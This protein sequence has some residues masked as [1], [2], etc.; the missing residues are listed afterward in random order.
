MKRG[1]FRVLAALLVFTFVISAMT[2]TISALSYVKGTNNVSSSYK[3]GKFYKQLTQLPLTGNQRADVLAVALSQVQ[4]MESNS[5]SDLSGTTGGSNNYTE[6]CYN[7]GYDVGTNYAWCAAFVTWCLRQSGVN[8]VGTG[9]SNLARSHLGDS[10]Y[11]YCEISCGFWVSQLQKCGYWKG[12]KGRF[13]GTYAPKPGDL[14][15]FENGGDS[16]SDHIGMVVYYDSSA[17]KV[18][19]VEGN[20][21]GASGVVANGGRVA[22]KSY[23]YSST[24][25]YGYGA[26]PYNNSTSPIDYSGKNPSAGIYIAAESNKYLYS[27]SACTGTYAVL[28]KG[29]TFEVTGIAS[30]SGLNAVL[31]CKYNGNT[32]YIKNNSDRII[33][34]TKTVTDSGTGSGSES[35]SGSGSGGTTTTPTTLTTTTAYQQ[36]ACI[37]YINNAGADGSSNPYSSDN[38]ANR[39]NPVSMACPKQTSDGVLNVRGWCM[40]NG[41]QSEV[42]YSLNGGT[43]WTK[44]STATYSNGNSAHKNAAVSLGLTSD[45]AIVTNAVFNVSVDLSAYNGKSVD[46][47]F[48]RI[49]SGTMYVSH[50]LTVTGVVVGGSLVNPVINGT[51]ALSSTSS[52]CPLAYHGCIDSINGTKSATYGIS[53]NPYRAVSESASS[54]HYVTATGVTAAAGNVLTVSGW[55]LMRGGQNKYVYSIDGKNWYNCG[56]TLKTAEAAVKTAVENA[57]YLKSDGDSAIDTANGRYVLNLDLSGCAGTTVNVYVGVV[58]AFSGYTNRVTQFLVIKNVSVPKTVYSTAAVVNYIDATG[59]DGTTDTNYANDLVAM[60]GNIPTIPIAN[61]ISCSKKTLRITGWCMI[62]GG[63]Q[64]TIKWSLDGGSTWSGTCSGAYAD[65]SDSNT[66]C[67][68][69]WCNMTSPSVTGARF[70]V[71]ANLSDVTGNTV[72]VTFGRLGADGKMYKFLTITDVDMTKADHKFVTAE[73]VAPTCTAAGSTEKI[74]CSSCGYVKQ[75]STSVSATGHSWKDATCTAPKTCMV[76]SATTG[77]ANGHVWVDANCT[78]PKTCSVCKVT[79][80]KATGHSWQPATC[81]SPMTCSGCKA[82]TGSAAGHSWKD[83]TCTAPKTCTVCST[84]TGSAKGH[85]WKDATVTAPKT[86]SVCG[87]TEGKPIEKTGDVNVIVLAGQSNAY[88][89]TPTDYSGYNIRNLYGNKTYSNIFIHYNN[90]NL[91]ADSSS[92]DGFRWRTITSNAAFERYKVG[93]GAEASTRFGPEL[94]LANYLNETYPDEDFYII[95]FTAAGTFLNGQWFASDGNG[96]DPYGLKDDMGDYLYAQMRQYI[97]SSIGMIESATGKN[98]KITSFMWVQG[99]SDAG[100]PLSAG[101]YKNCEQL[102]V[103]SLRSDFAAY[104]AEGGISFIDMTISEKIHADSSSDGLA[105]AG[106]KI[107]LYSSEINAAKR[108]NAQYDFTGSVVIENSNAG[109]AK[110]ILIDYPTWCSKYEIGYD[111]DRY[112]FAPRDMEMLGNM[113]GISMSFLKDREMTHSHTEEIISGVEATE[114]TD[115]LT[116]G[117]RC[118]EC[119]EMIVS[120]DVIPATGKKENYAA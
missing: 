73:G 81:T 6:Y 94:G 103:N 51:L 69:A 40:I 18:Y 49:A 71:V 92:A 36:A 110:S 8:K 17:G 102:L 101:A 47:M 80:G 58:P 31:K 115:G 96:Y 66:T 93:I 119:G 24:S 108:E 114:T 44:C 52:T 62:N 34:L 104:S 3:S 22:F 10:R 16:W 98:A 28:P 79:T 85:S 57:G 78:T 87:A 43:T 50:F 118:S 19:T 95:K 11:I 88:G 86:C 41:G 54:N 2:P 64:N 33:Q 116:D 53:T 29:T 5:S 38:S 77:S 111:S 7:F 59:P 27:S 117:V 105:V 61:A 107:W 63:Q 99:E 35:G 20:T 12:S 30:G 13:G 75:A 25:I 76:C 120:Q 60:G 15:F 32:Y 55:L 106:N 65:G 112:H 48:G 113:L 26:L 45:Y 23:S 14:I 39:F 84:T 46:V 100:S 72:N 74:Y 83:A 37:D 42:C 4:Y 82:T 1:F 56:G 109:I 91:A 90:I 89:A 21:S 68:K 9:S 97:S 70:D 67:A